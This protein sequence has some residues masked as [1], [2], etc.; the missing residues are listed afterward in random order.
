[1][2]ET[3][4][5]FALLLDHAGYDGGEQLRHLVFYYH[6]IVPALGR[7]PDAL[8]RPKNWQSFMTDHFSPVEFSWDWGHGK[9]RTVIRFSIEPVGTYVGTSL[10]PCNRFAMQQVLHQCQHLLPQ[11]DLSL[12]NYLSKEMLSYDPPLHDSPLPSYSVWTEHQSRTFIAFDLGKDG[13]MLKVYFMPIFKARAAKQ[14]TWTVVK[15][16]LRGL[17]RRFSLD[18][19]LPAMDALQLF[20]THS[21]EDKKLETEI[22]AID[23]VAPAR[24]RFKIYMRTQSTSFHS[25]RKIMTLGGMVAD[26]AASS[27]ALEEL[28]ALWDLILS[29]GMGEDAAVN[30]D[31]WL[32]QQSHRTAGILYYFDIK[33]GQ[34]LPG[35]K[36]Y[37]PVRHYA[38]SDS[39]VVEGLQRY[40]ESRSRSQDV[41]RYLAALK[42]IL[43]LSSAKAGSKEWAHRGLQTYLGC[44]ISEGRLKL[45]SYLS[46]RLYNTCND[47]SS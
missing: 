44:S 25:M 35:V 38:Q 27:S 23:C 6:C 2:K 34:A 45:T 29:N 10:D 31:A 33:Q 15:Q 16:S 9:E 32:P 22:F 41:Q 42:S 20:L 1:M 11:C 24:S 21:S 26:P 39:A 36:V 13:V 14:S 30:E 4:R 47:S 43:R 3:A 12:F 28:K 40:F 7:G 46:P 8:G 17:S 18:L 5:P 19:L 37:I